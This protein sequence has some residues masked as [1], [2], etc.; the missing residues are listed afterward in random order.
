[1]AISPHHALVIGP[2]GTFFPSGTLNGTGDYS[3]QKEWKIQ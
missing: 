1:L 3:N 2:R